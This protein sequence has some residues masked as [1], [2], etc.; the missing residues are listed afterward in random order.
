MSTDDHAGPR[1]V[2]RFH[3]PPDDDGGR[4]ERRERG[5]PPMLVGFGGQQMRVV[6]PDTLAKLVA[7]RR[8]LYGENFEVALDAVRKLSPGERMRLLLD[9]DDRSP[10]V[11]TGSGSFSS[12][13]DAL[14]YGGPEPDPN[15][16]YMKR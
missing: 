6:D 3:I 8:E 11:D 10:G 15:S 5:D 14:D 1:R 16:P 13:Y 7:R 9:R 4:T 2:P 12:S